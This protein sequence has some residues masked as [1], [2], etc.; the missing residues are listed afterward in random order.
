MGGARYIRQLIDTVPPEVPEP[1]RSWLALAAYNM[2]WGHLLDARDL[3]RRRGGDSNRW[4]D[5]RNSLPML[6]Q[7]RYYKNTKFGY[8]RGHETETY[9][10][11][12][13]T[14]Y[15]MLLYMFADVKPP[16]EAPPPPPQPL[17][18]D[19]LNIRTPVL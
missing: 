14:Y 8:A 3:T 19:E 1:D 10:G 18:A 16:E 15:D 2:G 17:P 4:L 12:I 6:T 11:N 13:R 5:V 7:A 9:V